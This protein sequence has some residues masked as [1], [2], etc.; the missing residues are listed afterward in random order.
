M[1]NDEIMFQE[2]QLWA[3]RDYSDYLQ[4]IMFDAY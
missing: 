2:S 1:G 3:A 4:H